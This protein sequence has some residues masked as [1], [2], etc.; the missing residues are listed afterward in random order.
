MADGPRALSPTEWEQLNHVVGTVFRPTMFQNYPQLF[1]EANI[2]NLR[3]VGD[4]GA[5]VCH[6]GMTERPAT[7]AGCRIDV[8]SIG[9]VATLDEHRGKGYA[10]AAFQDACDKAARDGIDVMLISGG[11]RL[12]VRVGCR[13]VGLDW[14]FTLDEAQA[15]RLASARPPGGG[16]FTFA[17]VSGADIP[18]MRALHAAEHVRYIRRAEDWE[19]ALDCRVVMNTPS[20]F[21]G[22]RLGDVLVAYV[23]VHQ[24]DKVRRR[25]EDPAMV[26]VVEF[27]GQRAAV[28]ASLPELRRHYG[29]PSIRIHVQGSDPVMAGVLRRGTGLDGT[30]V[31]SSGTLRVINFP[32]L[33]ERCRP[34]LAER[35]GWGA[36]E[37]MTFRA[38]APPGSERGGFSIRRGGAE[39]RVADLG[40]LACLLF[41][42]RTRVEG[43]SEPTGDATLLADLARAL[44]L[45]TLWYGISYV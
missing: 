41:G 45:P 40:S 20:D 1:N 32:Q 14:D 19:M 22:V 36:V 3:V 12:Y 7:L 25:P 30:P 21:W 31:A 24:P 42:S 9:A 16:G 10:S 35:I 8:A 28:F 34:L 15:E 33:M 2:E 38:E 18:E 13:A 5:L 27:A 4:G 17:P 26:R 37:G 29:T 44:P 11:R 43:D 23:I 6:V 39:V